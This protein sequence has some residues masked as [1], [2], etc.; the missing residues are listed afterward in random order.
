MAERAKLRRWFETLRQLAPAQLG[1]RLYYNCEGWLAA[2]PPVGPAPSTRRLCSRAFALEHQRSST[3]GAS[4]DR[5]RAGLVEFLN[6][7]WQV[8]ALDGAWDWSLQQ[9]QGGSGPSRLWKFQLHSFRWMA[10]LAR[11]HGPGSLDL[12]DRLSRSWIAAHPSPR[13]RARA[14]AWNSYTMANRIEQWAYAETLCGPFLSSTVRAAARQQAQFLARHFEWDLRGNHLVRN[15]TGLLVASLWLQVP[16][17]G[18][19]MDRAAQVLRGALRRQLCSDGGH[20]ERSPMYHLVVMEDFAQCLELL[21]CAGHLPALQRSLAEGLQR[22]ADWSCSVM[23]PD[24]TIPLFN[25]SAAGVVPAPAQLV[26]RVKRQCQPDPGASPA[27][28]ADHRPTSGFAVLRAGSWL[29]IVDGGPLGPREQPG[30]A[31]CGLGSMVASYHTERI[32]EDTGVFEY[33]HG[34]RRSYA[35]STA[36]HSTLQF[37]GEEQADCWGEFRMGRRVRRIGWH[38]DARSCQLEYAWQSGRIHRRC[39]VVDQGQLVID[40]EILG[41]R[42]ERMILRWH[43]APGVI[44]DGTGPS[45]W[46]TPARTRIH[47]ELP[48]AWSWEIDSTPFF[49]AFG[50]ERQRCSLVGRLHA[51][52]PVRAQAVFTAARQG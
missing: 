30:H 45:T 25:D 8:S 23:W 3:D 22:M 24:G 26:A 17:S 40:D 43:W 34:T 33:E 49:P 36:A 5:I 7:E 18:F 31:H 32:L 51:R 44:P 41:A 4:A 29:A 21:R 52:L 38:N 46:V 28:N 9:F 11:G 47:V 42:L 48:S 10:V 20:Y 19:W 37:E 1:W 16:E 15:A 14:L 50:Q 35:R 12:M 6:Q 13:R 2:A 39:V 27:A